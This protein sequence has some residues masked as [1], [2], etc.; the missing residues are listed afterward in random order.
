MRG[1]TRSTGPGWPAPIEELLQRVGAG[2][3]VAFVGLYDAM[4]ARV[5]GLIR[6]VLVDPSQA[7]EV[8]QEVFLEIWQT[9][10]RFNH[11]RGAAVPW[12]LTIAR[13]RA[14]D[15]VRA[16]Q[17]SRERDHRIGSAQLEREY[18][19]VTEHIE[20]VDVSAR[21]RSKMADLTTL[22][23]QAVEL[24]YMAELSYSEISDLL[25]VPIGTVKTRVR[26]GLTR[27]RKDFATSA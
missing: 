8:A 4:A 9:A 1:D 25:K 24:T 6:Y 12:I 10:A 26:D 2:D 5:F 19:S 14:V 27:L 20:A 23:R 22:Q 18:D 17:S 13:R 3:R 7:E 16:S 11:E 15:R 21:V